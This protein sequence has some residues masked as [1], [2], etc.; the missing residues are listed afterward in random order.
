VIP[1]SSLIATG[2]GVGKLP[3]APGTWAAL[4]ALPPGMAMAH[5]IGWQ[6]L[7]VVA[8]A[9]SAIG[10]WAADEHA[11]RTGVLDPSDCV[12]DEIAAQWFPLVV[13]A[14]NGELFSVGGLAASFLLFR[15]FDIAKP[16]PIAPLE[17]LPGGWGVMADDVAAGVAAAALVAAMLWA[18]WL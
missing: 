2:F 7:L 11:R 14:C 13:L 18:G 17:H 9:A 16:W 10:V 4:F 3:V 15:F 1:L 12:I 6:G 8:I 5:V